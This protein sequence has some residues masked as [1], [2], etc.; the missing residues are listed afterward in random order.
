MGPMW[1]DRS[2]ELIA[3]VHSITYLA[4]IPCLGSVRTVLSHIAYCA[5][6]R[7]C[8][9]HA[10]LFFFILIV[11]HTNSKLRVKK[12]KNAHSVV[13]GVKK[14][15]KKNNVSTHVKATAMEFCELLWQV[16]YTSEFGIRVAWWMDI[17]QNI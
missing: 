15:N 3:Y 8:E 16:R 6:L 4:M 1:A 5:R 17:C 11:P 2:P 14:E 13:S 10:L 7:E 12:E 9:R